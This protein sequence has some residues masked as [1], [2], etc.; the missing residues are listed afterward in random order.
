MSLEL[1]LEV[2]RFKYEDFQMVVTKLDNTLFQLPLPQTVYESHSDP[3]IVPYS[4]NP[5]ISNVPLHSSQLTDEFVQSAKAGSVQTMQLAGC[6]C[7]Y[8]H[9]VCIDT[10]R[11]RGLK[12]LSMSA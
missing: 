1:V 2:K 7:H 12:I 6:G 5:V 10:I 11:G 9:D 4:E 3:D 8:R